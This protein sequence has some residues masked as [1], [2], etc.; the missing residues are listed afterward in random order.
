MSSKTKPITK[1]ITDAD[2]SILPTPLSPTGVLATYLEWLTKQPL[3][4]NTRRTYRVRVTQYCSFL[5]TH[6]THY[7]DP[8]REQHARDYAVRDYKAHLQTARHAKPSS[9]NL[10][11]AAL[12]HFYRFLNLGPPRVDREDLPQQAPRALEPEEQVRFL[13]AVERST[14]VR[15]RAIALLLFYTGLR[16][17]EAAA[18]NL[19]DAPVSAR[20]GKVIVGCISDKGQDLRNCL[21]SPSE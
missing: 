2:T 1:P 3:A 17:G 9:V 18:L 14:S 20:K 21:K 7:G 13:R 15:D 6:P 12:D 5:A 11:L 10:T 16:I 8:L 19:D 4:D